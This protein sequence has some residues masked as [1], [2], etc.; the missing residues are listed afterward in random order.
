M[1][2]NRRTFLSTSATLTA[3]ST[4]DVHSASGDQTKTTVNFALVGL[5][6]LSTN[7]IAPAL[8][9]TK[10]A[11]LV[12]IVTG[13]PA[14]ETLWAEKYGIQKQNID[15]YDRLSENEDIDVVDIVLPN[16]MHMEFTVR[17]ANAGKHVLCEKPMSNSSEDCR[18]MIQAC[19]DNGRKLAG[20][21][22]LMDVGVYALQACRYISG[23]EP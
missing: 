17:G 3:A 22:A 6:S 12:G 18:T 21:G 1:I 10:H 7:Q 5:G 19:N 2:L 14:K 11:K 15:H 13:T 4:L 16:G 9:K 20:G 23:E 8:Q